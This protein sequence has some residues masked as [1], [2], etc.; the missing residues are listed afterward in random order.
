MPEGSTLII[1]EANPIFR[2]GLSRIFA[3]AGYYNTI[4]LR[5]VTQLDRIREAPEAFLLDPE[6]QAQSIGEAVGTIRN[7]FPTSKIITLSSSYNKCQL[8]EALRAGSDA[9]IMNFISCEAL[10]KSVDLVLLGECVLPAEARDLLC[11]NFFAAP[12][13][14]GLHAT[15]STLSSREVEVLKCLSLG[16]ANKVIARHFGITES[17]VKVHVKAILRKI[18]ARNRTEAAI[19]ARD[20]DFGRDADAQSSPQEGIQHLRS[21]ATTPDPRATSRGAQNGSVHVIPTLE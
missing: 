5:D 20:H 19:W 15:P 21:I 13:K 6:Q 17:T 3:E 1:V 14:L 4:S 12:D 16:Q 9:Y 18:H 11:S 2:E 7:R 10:V 8:T